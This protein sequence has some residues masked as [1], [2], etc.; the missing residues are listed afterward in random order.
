MKSNRLLLVFLAVVF[1][2]TTTFAAPPSYRK[3]VLRT[4][5]NLCMRYHHESTSGCMDMLEFDIVPLTKET[6]IKNTTN[7]KPILTRCM[8]QFLGH[9]LPEAQMLLSIDPSLDEAT[10]SS[11]TIT[12]TTSIDGNTHLKVRKKI[13]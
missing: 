12:T 8:N 13:M 3:C 9:T 5:A 4:K 2:T 6:C 10:T 11:T 7:C 1:T